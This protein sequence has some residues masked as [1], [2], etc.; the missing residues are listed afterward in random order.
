MPITYNARA[1]KEDEYGQAYMAPISSNDIRLTSNS[2]LM[3]PPK[4]RESGKKNNKNTPN[5]MS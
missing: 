3:L 5:A 4:V 2:N 1:I